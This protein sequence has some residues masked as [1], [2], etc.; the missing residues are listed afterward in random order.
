M[1]SITFQLKPERSKKEGHKQH[2]PSEEYS[3]PSVLSEA[4]V[5]HVANQASGK[6]R[7]DE[8]EVTQNPEPQG[9]DG[10]SNKKSPEDGKVNGDRDYIETTN[11]KA[12]HIETT[13]VVPKTPL[14]KAVVVE[15]PNKNSQTMDNSNNTNDFQISGTVAYPKIFEEL[16][17]GL[18]IPVDIPGTR[19]QVLEKNNA[20]ESLRTQVLIWVL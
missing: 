13:P 3:D 10:V 19:D 1:G 4:D 6:E 15:L 11:N 7:N 20:P 18:S 5:V 17:S 8:S 12:L 9:S 16:F 2:I 14:R